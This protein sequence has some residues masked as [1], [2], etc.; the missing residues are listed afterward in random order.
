M[1]ATRHHSPHYNSHESRIHNLLCREKPGDF[2][3][4]DIAKKLDLT[5]RSVAA[6][7][8]VIPGVRIKNRRKYAHTESRNRYAFAEAS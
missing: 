6:Y 4:A 1:M 3:A 2:T 5:A 7:L 8:K